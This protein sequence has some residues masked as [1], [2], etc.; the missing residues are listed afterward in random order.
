[1]QR[2]PD[3]IH[4]GEHLA[5]LEV[6][7]SM[8]ADDARWTPTMAG[9]VTL[10]LVDKWAE[11]LRGWLA[12]RP[13][14]VAA[15]RGAIE[16]VASGPVRNAL[17]AVVDSITQS[18]GQ[19]RTTVSSRVLAYAALL[20]DEEAWSLAADVYRTFLSFAATESDLELGA[21]AWIRLGT[22][23]VMDGHLQEGEIA[24]D[25]ARAM[26]ASG[27]QRYMELLAEH[28][29]AIV[30]LQRGN[31][32][33]ADVR[34]GALADAC[35]SE[36]ASNA[37]LSDVLARA[38]HDRGWVAIHRGQVDRAFGLLYDAMQYATEPR[39][40]NRVLQDLA[41]AFAESG[42]RVTACKAMRHIERSADDQWLR[43]IASLNL[44]HYATLDGAETV[45]EQYRRTLSS[46]PL[47][48]RLMVG[49][50]MFVGEGCRAFG[51]EAQ[52]VA[53]YGRA[54]VVAE[55]HAL[56]AMLMEAEAAQHAAP[57]KQPE[58]IVAEQHT[59][60]SPEADRV[61]RAIDELVGAGA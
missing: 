56:N 13:S 35:R 30:A 31:L 5:F 18:W 26:A 34:L 6:L 49:Y 55:R 19:P 15:V 58:S 53:A 47:P 51:R 52:A 12:P 57:A 29:L 37:S 54:V 46:A 1:M 32:P 41:W 36:M 38:L 43:W 17:A 23:L 50:H 7:G 28:G 2:A 22:S 21:H 8:R 39:R 61:A 16:K 3:F 44:M 9:F 25:A 60:W 59:E 10:R 20:Y 4:R 45:F 48:P 40:K 24:H 14:E 27:G 42:D 33:D 11:A